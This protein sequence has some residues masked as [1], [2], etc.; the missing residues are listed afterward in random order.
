[1]LELSPMSDHQAAFMFLNDTEVATVEALAE[2]IF[3]TDASGP[4]AREAQAVVYIDRTLA[5]FGSS[6]QKLYRRGLAELDRFTIASRGG[7]PFTQLSQSDQVAI[8][9]E[10]ES[11]EVTPASRVDAPQTSTTMEA[12]SQQEN[13][14]PTD[15]S[16]LFALFAAVR[17]H[18]I[19]GVFCDPLY[20]GN[21]NFIGWRQVGFPGA[22]WGYSAEQENPEFDSTTIP[23]KSLADLRKEQL[24]QAESVQEGGKH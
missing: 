13:A 8:V 22:Q 15:R 2:C 19:E 16:L 12:S 17:E 20:G 6:L 10:L 18:T 1:M 5:G 24:G 4:G 23:I 9:K 21:H 14:P 3:P 11:W 7:K